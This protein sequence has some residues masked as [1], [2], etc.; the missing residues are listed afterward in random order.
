V[1]PASD[2]P[3]PGCGIQIAGRRG[4]VRIS[5]RH[6]EKNRNYITSELT[7]KELERESWSPTLKTVKP[8]SWRIAGVVSRIPA[9]RSGRVRAGHAQGQKDG[10]T[11]NGQKYQIKTMQKLNLTAVYEL[12]RNTIQISYAIPIRRKPIEFFRITTAGK[13]Y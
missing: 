8:V 2:I 6:L 4:R 12:V 13:I 10:T 5:S 3:R 7:E 1:R 11:K 9:C